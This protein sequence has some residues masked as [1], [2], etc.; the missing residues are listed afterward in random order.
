MAGIRFVS[1]K[2]PM[3][4]GYCSSSN[5]LNG[6]FRHGLLHFAEQKWLQTIAQLLSLFP[7]LFF[8]F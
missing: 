5:G 1:D 4:S 3:V 6:P 7:N 8:F 2:K